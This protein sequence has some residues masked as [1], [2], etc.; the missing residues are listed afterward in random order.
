MNAQPFQFP[1]EKPTFNKE[2]IQ[3]SKL[4]S[5]HSFKE[6]KKAYLLSL[7]KDPHNSFVLCD[8]GLI[9]LNLKNASSALNYFLQALIQTSTNSIAFDNAITLICEQTGPEKGNYEVIS[10]NYTKHSSNPA[11]V[12]LMI[13]G[14]LKE[15]RTDAAEAI[16]GELLLLPQLK[17]QFLNT[18]GTTIGQ[19]FAIPSISVKIFQ[20]SFELD[21]SQG[22]ILVQIIAN[23]IWL[24]EFPKAKEWI[25]KYRIFKFKD[26]REIY[27]QEI[28]V[29]ENMGDHEQA[30]SVAKECLSK[31]SP[32]FN[33]N[34]KSFLYQ[35]LQRIQNSHADE[36]IKEYTSRMLT[37]NEI[38]HFSWL[39][40]SSISDCLS[41]TTVHNLHKKYWEISNISQISSNIVPK[42]QR[43]GDEKLRVGF[44]SADFCSH[45]VQQFFEPL[46]MELKSKPLEI[47]LYSNTFLADNV[48]ER[49][50]KSVPNWRNITSLDDTAAAHLVQSDKIDILI[51]L[52]GHT[53]HNRLHLFALRPAPIQCTYLGYTYSTGLNTMDYWILDSKVSSPT[54]R[55][56]STETIWELDRPWV[57]Y[58]PK[59]QILSR[60]I[61]LSEKR[62]KIVFGTSN[63]IRKYSKTTISLFAK[64]LQAIPNSLLLLKAQGLDS[65]QPQKGFIKAFEERGISRDRLFFAGYSPNLENHM[66]VLQQIDIALDTTPFSGGTTTCDLL[67]MGI[68]VLTLKGDSF[69][70]RMSAAFLEWIGLN[71]WVCESEEE[72]INKALVYSLDIQSLNEVRSGLRD[73]LQAGKL[74]DPADLAQHLHESFNKMIEIKEAV[75]K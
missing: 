29:L 40:V 12:A 13:L 32:D 41:Q 55:S 35:N 21:N 72:F 7:R 24:K 15:K 67:S 16:M 46:L 45:P 26:C 8:L 63:H 25:S 5:K 38:F 68:P 6:A 31:F 34:T 59:P 65:P 18:L 51:D 62:D 27:W 36:L 37:G 70:S 23:L 2:A 22:T 56:Y 49:F 52:G 74:F 75:L 48:T 14:N 64:V 30:I 17:T 71:H 47:F 20:K 44:V 60:P 9:E 54:V 69:V 50:K 4:L 42:F 53:T 33:F 73:L 66:E 39:F 11:I 3:G 61:R 43:K 58:S 19:F 10:E 1:K 28:T 57:A